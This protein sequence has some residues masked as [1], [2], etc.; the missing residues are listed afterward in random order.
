MPFGEPFDGYFK[1]VITPAVERAGCQTLRADQ[2]YGARR[3]MRDVWDQIW[4]AR[5]VV[6]DV[7][8]ANP[9]VN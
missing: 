8:G 5:L 2:I 9:N 3:V 1:H 6:V 4:R 7:S